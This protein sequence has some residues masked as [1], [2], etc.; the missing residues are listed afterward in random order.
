MNTE[1]FNLSTHLQHKHE[2]C[3]KL[4]LYIYIYTHT[5]NEEGN[6][7]VEFYL[8]GCLVDKW[9]T[10]QYSAWAELHALRTCDTEWPFSSRSNKRHCH[11]SAP[12]LTSLLPYNSCFH[13]LFL[14]L[15][16]FPQNSKFSLCTFLYFSFRI[17]LLLP[18]L[19]L[20]FRFSTIIYF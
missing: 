11:V 17:F 20:L 4:P 15:P 9:I 5:H 14:C 16:D 3:A 18:M 1:L 6:E 2:E 12:F 13:S 19:F 10:M 8:R 7:S